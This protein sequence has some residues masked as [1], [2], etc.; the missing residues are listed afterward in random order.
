[1]SDSTKRE[2][3]AWLDPYRTLIE[4]KARA[5]PVQG[6]VDHAA[7][8]TDVLTSCAVYY[9]AGDL[10][11]LVSLYAEDARYE[12]FLGVRQGRDQVRNHYAPLIRR[13]ARTIHLMCNPTIW[14]ESATTA[15]A[16]SYLHAVV[17]T[18]DGISYALG[19]LYQDKLR[20]IDGDWKL[21]ERVVGDGL[22]YRIEA[23]APED[24]LPPEATV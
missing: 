14:V 23:V 12:S 16:A 5:T 13:Y 7:A 9:D 6:A 1:V 4:H 10:E 3:K 8:I 17:Q 21:Q 19:A 11:S 2:R 20:Q 24:R 22:A 15:H 18:R